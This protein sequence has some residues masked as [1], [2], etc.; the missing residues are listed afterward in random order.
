MQV[1]STNS[2][3]NGDSRYWAEDRRAHH[4]ERLGAPTDSLATTVRAGRFLLLPDR[5]WRM[6]EAV[7]HD[8]R[9]LSHQRGLDDRCAPVIIVRAIPIASSVMRRRY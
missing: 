4:V 1:G 5:H 2:R 3:Q 7:R 9:H 6:I 8:P